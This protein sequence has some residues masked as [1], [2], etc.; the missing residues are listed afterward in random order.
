MLALGLVLVL[1]L[2]AGVSFAQGASVPFCSV[3][4]S[5]VHG[6]VTTVIEGPGTHE[7]ASPA[8]KQGRA[9]AWNLLRLIAMG[10]MRISTAKQDGGIAQVS[11]IDYKTFELVPY[12]GVFSRYCTVV[13]G[14]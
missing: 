13:S 2:P 11:S 3:A 4:V 10:D 6:C 7:S 12:W 14:S 1:C 8:T 5:P 9:C